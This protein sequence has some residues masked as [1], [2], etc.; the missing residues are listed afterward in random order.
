[1]LE[2][3]P[4]SALP[5]TDTGAPVE[6][7]QELKV[8][9]SITQQ[10]LAA[11]VLSKFEEARKAKQPIEKRLIDC[12][13]RYQSKYSQQKLAELREIN[14]PE[15][16]IPLT[17]IKCR[18]L[19][20]WLVDI[21]FSTDELPYDI[22]PT[23]IPELPIEVQNVIWE[24]VRDAIAPIVDYIPFEDLSSL[25]LDAKSLAEREL[26]KQVEK[27]SSKLAE[28]FKKRLDDILI[29][30]GFHEAL[31]KFCVDIAIY[32]TAIIKGG[33]L[34]KEKGYVRTAYGL[35]PR[36]KEVYVFKT[37]SPFNIYPSPY[38]VDFDDY[39][40]EVLQLLP[41][42]LYD[43]KDLPGYNSDVIEDVLNRYESGY[44]FHH[45]NYKWDVDSLEGN[46]GAVE[47]D[48]PYI[49]VLEFWGSVR[50]KLLQDYGI[51]VE[52]P[53]KYYEATI[54]VIENH[55]LKAVLNEDP[56]GMKPYAKASFINVPY[57]F[58]GIALP[59]VLAPIQDSVNAM[60]RAIVV[61]AVLSSGPI[62]ERNIDRIS[63]SDPKVLMPWHIYD[64]H[65]SAMNNA[66]AYRFNYPQLTADR[67]INTMMFYI[68]LA[69]DTCGIPS[70]THGS[71]MPT[72]SI[73]RTATGLSMFIN[74]ATRG[75]KAVLRNIDTG[76]IEPIIKRMYY[77]LVTKSKL[78]DIPDLKIRTKGTIALAE[79]EM[80]ANRALELLRI[81]S[82]P[83]DQQLTGLEGRKYLLT[84]IAK[85]IGIDPDKVFAP[86]DEI[87]Q[88][89]R[90]IIEQTQA[91]M[92]QTKSPLNSVQNEA[93][94]KGLD[95]SQFV[96][97]N[98]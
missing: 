71:L 36:D 10:N 42:D 85:S 67:L 48:Y 82:N 57:S 97:E 74:N 5:Q 76:I 80:E 68:K 77:T 25:V 95:V 93:V 14:A 50:G 59:E 55:V 17:S 2:F 11:Y 38:S 30:G 84:S 60:A 31:S 56:L 70:Y 91:Q 89:L 37:V 61:N 40:I 65:E 16:Y 96:E 23:P 1:M 21:L 46:E 28:G 54:W 33:V 3:I 53:D 7:M 81:I 86:T 35:E 78:T 45:L 83:L 26:K 4:V 13:E 69:D 9:S 52:D 24:R 15:V 88:L 27:Y 62:V 41:Q 6:E 51:S 18:A 12:L 66:P 73:G 90:P 47:A 32:P 72:G 64:V 44:R 22:S 29:E 75:I 49:D 92:A 39:V 19:T 87:Q 20:A 98:G 34:K 58:W 63:H 79:R 94:Q 8:D 43:L